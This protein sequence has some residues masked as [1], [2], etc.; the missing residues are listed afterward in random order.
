VSSVAD[1]LNLIELGNYY[2]HPNRNRGRSDPRQCVYHPASQGSGPGFTGPIATL[3]AH[4]SCDGIVEYASAALGGTMRGNLIYAEFQRNVL[5]RAVLSADGRSVLSFGALT[6]GFEGPLDVT[7]GPDGTLYIAQ[8]NGGSVVYLEPDSDGDSCTDARE[9][10]PDETLGGRRDPNNPWDFYDVSGDG[11]VTIGDDIL[12][13]VASFG[14][15][16]GPSYVAGRDR[17][18]PPKGG[19]PWDM[20]PPDG[21]INILDDVYGAALQFG[22]S[23]LG[24]GPAVSQRVPLG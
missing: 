15:G 4:C 16:N 14:P 13:V 9:L 18:P 19:D 8:F 3:P 5:S 21:A 12:A 2:G 23:C 7:M 6:T 22:H 17:S 20:G 10:G 24:P 11:V 1:E